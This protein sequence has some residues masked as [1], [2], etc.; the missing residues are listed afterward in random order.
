MGEGG[1]W[2]DVYVVFLAAGRGGVGCMYRIFRTW[3]YC[4][5]KFTFLR[6][7]IARSLM[8]LSSCGLETR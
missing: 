2:S 3:R 4:S 5:L 8:G 6:I 7:N 1:H